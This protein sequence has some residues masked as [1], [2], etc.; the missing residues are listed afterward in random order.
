MPSA[1]LTPFMTEQETTT[2]RETRYCPQCLT[3]YTYD[4]S[5]CVT[6]NVALTAEQPRDESL[7]HP[8]IDVPAI[9][10]SVLFFVFYSQLPGEAQSFGLIAVVVGLATLVVM[11][12]VHYSE[13]LG[14]R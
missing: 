2:K 1:I 6:C 13:W 9:A 5:E 3:R 7:F 12:F 11:R 8:K 4:A 14:R 10:L